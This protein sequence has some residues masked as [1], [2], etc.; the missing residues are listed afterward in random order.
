M[1]LAFFLILM[2]Y[3][4]IVVKKETLYEKCRTQDIM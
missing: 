3:K 2:K 1:N 4:S